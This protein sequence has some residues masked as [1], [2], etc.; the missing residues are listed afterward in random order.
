MII[1]KQRMYF[2][3]FQESSASTYYF[4]HQVGMYVIGVM[5]HQNRNVKFSDLHLVGT[6]FSG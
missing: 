5:V 2:Y 1:I 3:Y 6:S 4:L